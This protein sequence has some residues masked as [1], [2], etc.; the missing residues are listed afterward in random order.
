M[1]LT[2]SNVLDSV[3]LKVLQVNQSLL[4]WRFGLMVLSL[5]FQM[6]GGHYKLVVGL[7]VD[8]KIHTGV[9]STES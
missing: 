4:K 3:S 8:R 2:L 5:N 1:L 6:Q 9:K 7:M